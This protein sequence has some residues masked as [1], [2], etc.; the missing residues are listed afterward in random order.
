MKANAF[1][2]RARAFRG[3]RATKNVGSNVPL[4]EVRA[5]VRQSRGSTGTKAVKRS[6]DRSNYLRYDDG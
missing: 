5:D 2:R 1:E 3:K 4:R 6:F